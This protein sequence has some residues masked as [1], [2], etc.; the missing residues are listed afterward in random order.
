[1]W[2]LKQCRHCIF[3][4]ESGFSLYHSDDRVRVCRRQGE[5][6]IDACIRPNDGNRGRSV[7]V[8]G[9]IHHGGGVSWSW[10][11]EP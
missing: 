6:L 10:C 5:R 9:A 4:D 8:W 1:M 11:M 7:M 3:S 2:D